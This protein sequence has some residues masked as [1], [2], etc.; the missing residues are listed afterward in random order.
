MLYGK[1]VEYSYN[2]NIMAVDSQILILYALL[3]TLPWVSADQ[4]WRYDCIV[5]YDSIF[6][7]IFD[8]LGLHN[9]STYQNIIEL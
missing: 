5:R 4:S 2:L 8:Y 6:F 1:M 7:I 9:F 3:F